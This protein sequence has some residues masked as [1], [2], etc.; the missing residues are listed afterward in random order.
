MS[1]RNRKFKIPGNK[2]DEKFELPDGSYS[3]SDINQMFHTFLFNIRNYLL[4]VNNTQRPE[5]ESNIILPRLI[6]FDIK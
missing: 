5:V 2:W 3:I 1:Y 6:N 4:K